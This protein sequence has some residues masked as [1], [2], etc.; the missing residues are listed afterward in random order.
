[1]TRKC[2]AIRLAQCMDCKRDLLTCG[3]TEEDEDRFGLCRK[4]E[5]VF[6]RR[7]HDKRGVKQDHLPESE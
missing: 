3:C 2:D 1:M 5:S 4:H 7:K 6:E